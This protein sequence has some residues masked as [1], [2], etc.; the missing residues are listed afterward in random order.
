MEHLNPAQF[1]NLFLVEKALVLFY[2]DWCPFCQRF[3]PI[4]QSVIAKSKFTTGYKTYGAKLNEDA[5]PLWDKFSISAVPAIIAFER[6]S[7]VSRRDAKMGIGL[8]KPDLDSLLNDLD[9]R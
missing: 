4:F 7:I 6:G 8:T 5:N 9:W 3:I 1:E 2:A